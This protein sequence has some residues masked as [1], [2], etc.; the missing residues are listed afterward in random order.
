MTIQDSL[1]QILGRKE[2][3]ADLF[4]VIFFERFPGV[5]QYFSKVDL[6]RQALLLTMALMVIERHYTHRYAATEMYLKYLGTQHHLRG[7]PQDHY[8][9]FREALL[10][11]MEQ[12]HGKEWDPALA[13]QW[14]EAIDRATET[15]FQGYREHFHV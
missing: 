1:H 6:R 7:I 10:A 9:N 2:V 12:F 5:Q 13:G 4:Y 8:A 15:M 11:T 14:R 3:L